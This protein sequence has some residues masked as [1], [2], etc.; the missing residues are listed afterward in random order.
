MSGSQNTRTHRR[1]TDSTLLST[2]TVIIRVFGAEIDQQKQKMEGIRNWRD[3]IR[4]MEND[5]DS[6]EPEKK[7]PH[8]LNSLS[9]TTTTMARHSNSSPDNRNVSFCDPLILACLYH[10]IIIFVRL[11]MN[12]VV[13]LTPFICAIRVSRWL[14]LIFN[15]HSTETA[16]SDWFGTF[17]NWLVEFRV[18]WKS[19]EVVVCSMHWYEQFIYFV[20]HFKAWRMYLILCEVAILFIACNWMN[21]P[22]P[23]CIWRLAFLSKSLLDRS[24]YK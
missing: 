14:S 3:C 9:P 16:Y 2:P 11:G 6:D 18:L 1:A 21:Q 8:H 5:A 22:Q 7:R 4:N 19:F 17:A 20:S 12:F 23:H 13:F 10:L 24:H 15:T